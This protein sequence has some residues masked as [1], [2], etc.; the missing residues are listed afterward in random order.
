MSVGSEGFQ[1]FEVLQE[2][3]KAID[4]DET[5]FLVAGACAELYTQGQTKTGDIDIVV[6]DSIR[7]DFE[8]LLRGMNFSPRSEEVRRLWEGSYEGK[9]LVIDIVD[10]KYDGG[11]VW[12]NVDLEEFGYGSGEID[13]VSS[14]E[15]L[16]VQYL[17]EC[18]FWESNSERAYILLKTFDEH[19][20]WE[21]IEQKVEE[22]GIGEEY[23]DLDFL[24][25]LFE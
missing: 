4:E 9:E 5:I 8:E 10:S 19:L 23:L 12:N 13:S 25:S 6:P 3:V 15:D 22:E 1:F 11:R 17:V 16:I 2:G 18:C 24:I 7:E 21:Y 20:D 14:P